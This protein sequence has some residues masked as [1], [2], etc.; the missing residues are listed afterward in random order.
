VK[1]SVLAVG[2]VLLI[3]AVVFATS[4]TGSNSVG[5]VVDRPDTRL[6]I[7]MNREPTPEEISRLEKLVGCTPEK[8]IRRLGHPKKL[9]E[10]DDNRHNKIEWEYAWGDPKNPTG[11]TARLAFRHGKV[12]EAGYDHYRQTG[13]NVP[14]SW[15]T[16]R[17]ETPPEDDAK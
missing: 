15:F 1:C 12:A 3:C 17:Q 6:A 5:K 14:T 7:P 2:G 16:D 9:I 10:H 11:K 8:V 13:F 4:R